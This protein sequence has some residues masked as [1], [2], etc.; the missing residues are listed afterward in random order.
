VRGQPVL[1][2]D[3]N[4]SG[5]GDV[6]KMHLIEG[7]GRT[8]PY[9]GDVQAPDEK[10]AEAAAVAASITARISSDTASIRSNSR[11]SLCS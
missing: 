5:A 10:G 3:L 7:G 1:G 2:A 6:A 8:S 11:S 9:L 4:C